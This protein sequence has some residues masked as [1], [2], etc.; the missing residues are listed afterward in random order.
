MSLSL[1][2]Y[3]YIYI[4]IYI[5]GLHH[6][7]SVALQL[8]R[9]KLKGQPMLLGGLHPNLPVTARKTRELATYLSL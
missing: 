4:Y 6:K 2:L 9:G 3:I 8:L 7:L 1:S 5:D